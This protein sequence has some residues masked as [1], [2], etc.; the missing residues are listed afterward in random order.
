MNKTSNEKQVKI[1]FCYRFIKIYLYCKILYL[2]LCLQVLKYTHEA[3]SGVYRIEND[4]PE[5]KEI[6][7]MLAHYFTEDN[8]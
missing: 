6:E 4:G 1:L 8:I 2:E 7:K 3:M 5:K